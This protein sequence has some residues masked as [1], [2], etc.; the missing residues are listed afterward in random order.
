MK[1]NLIG[2]TDTSHAPP[3]DFYRYI[4]VEWISKFMGI[5]VEIPRET[6]I[7][8][9]YPKGK[10]SI[11]AIVHPFAPGQKLPSVK[12]TSRGTVTRITGKIF[13]AGAIQ[14]HVADRIRQSAMKLLSS[15]PL[16]RS[17]PCDI[18]IVQETAESAFGNGCGITLFVST[19]SGTVLSSSSSGEQG[20]KAEKV[21][22]EAAQQLI[23]VLAVDDIVVD[24]YLQD[25]VIILLA[26]ADGESE[27]LIGK[28]SLHTR[29]AIYV[30][31]KLM[32]AV[33]SLEP[34]DGSEESATKWRLKCRGVGFCR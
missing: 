32:G 23:D 5:H 3:L 2:G 12:L 14:M 11:S 20:K 16:T 7:R 24:E 8:G 25:Q 34:V 18:E 6:T 27:L 33:F 19:T 28:P 1:L 26:L 21:G 13:I 29:T 31:E 22:S 15:S 30:A 10:G 17:L 9:F 4:F